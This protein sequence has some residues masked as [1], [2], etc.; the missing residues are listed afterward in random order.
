MLT[1]LSVKMEVISGFG[2]E[3]ERTQCF[4]LCCIFH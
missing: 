4:L 1:F 2:H 3:F